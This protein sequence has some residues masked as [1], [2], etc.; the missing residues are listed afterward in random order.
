MGLIKECNINY[1]QTTSEIQLKTANGS[2]VVDYF[3]HIYSYPPK[4]KIKWNSLDELK[5]DLF[6][7]SKKDWVFNENSDAAVSENYTISDYTNGFLD[8]INSSNFFLKKTKKIQNALAHIPVFVVMNGQ[9]EIV[10]SKPSNFLNSKTINTY[11]N[12]KLYDY[13][14]A[15]DQSVEKR[16]E[17]GLFFLNKE[18]AEKYL[19]EVARS[20][21][22]G[23]KTVGLSIHCISLDSAYKITREHHPGIDFR[24]VPNF[25]EVKG[26][27][28]N[29]IEK[30]NLIFENEQQQL[31]LRNRSNSLFPY[32]NKIGTYLS[33]KF[34]FLQRNEYFKGVPIYIVQLTENPRNFWSEQ[35]FNTIG[36]LDN[37][38]S[39]TLQFFDNS[40]G[41]GQN[42]VMQGS[43][44]EVKNSDKFENYIFFNK[45]QAFNF[46]KK[47]GRKVARYNGSRTS[48]L[49]FMIRKPKI[50]VYNLE[51]FLEDWEDNIFEKSTKNNFIKETIF[52]C[53]AN[54][55]LL[56]SSTLSEINNF[57]ENFKPSFM[58][59]VSQTLDVKFRI[60]KRTI[61]A[62]FSIS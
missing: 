5:D 61:G 56:P 7:G 13:C 47:N 1:N 48:G 19:K 15:F 16:S 36:R 40:L 44:N 54:Y 21:F 26:I 46:R 51:D 34:S 29:K 3:Q 33:P 43:L 38:Y 55:F 49:G 2:K 41:F 53:K 45:D 30:H 24:Y 22:E 50:F 39:R 28:G 52:D 12:E 9:K 25:N 32:L 11:I 14:G 20:D 57:S 60:L 58:K 4:I 10:L 59:D 18:D 8:K 31:R 6:V 62:F 17:L 37:I 23:T 27:L 42:W 35:Y